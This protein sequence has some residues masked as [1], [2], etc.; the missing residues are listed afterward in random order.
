MRSA[1]RVL[2]RPGQGGVRR[3][4]GGGGGGHKEE[5][6]HHEDGHHHHHAEESP[7]GTKA[8]LFGEKPG[9]KRVREDWELIWYIGM[10]GSFLLAGIGLATKP[11][12][13]PSTWARR[14]MIERQEQAA[15]TKN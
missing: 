6:H 13:T 9:V 2:A 15:A 14:E 12:T 8:R 4:G 3:F 5:E 7:S 10:G 1:V 11:D